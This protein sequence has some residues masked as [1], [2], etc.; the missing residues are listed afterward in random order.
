MR[1]PPLKPALKLASLVS[2]LLVLPAAG[3]VLVAALLW[4]LG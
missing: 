1:R 2:V 3:N 4:A